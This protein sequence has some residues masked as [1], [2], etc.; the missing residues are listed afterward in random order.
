MSWKEDS[1]YSVKEE[2]NILVEEVLCMPRIRLQE[3]VNESASK[4]N[5]SKMVIT[6]KRSDGKDYDKSF[7]ALP[8]E[9]AFVRLFS[10]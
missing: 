3:S 5:E 10:E 7:N 4:I 1:V 9:D 8:V 2:L 6:L